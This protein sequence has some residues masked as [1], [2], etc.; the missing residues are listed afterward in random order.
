MSVKDLI[1]VA[2]TKIL[3]LANEDGAGLSVTFAWFDL[4]GLPGVSEP[5]RTAAATR[6]IRRSM[7]SRQRRRRGR[8]VV[9]MQR[10]LHSLG[11]K[12]CATGATAARCAVY[13]Q[14]HG[15]S[16]TIVGVVI[17]SSHALGIPWSRLGWCVGRR[18]GSH[19]SQSGSPPESATR[20]RSSS[21]HRASTA[22]T[23]GAPFANVVRQS[24]FLR[25]CKWPTRTIGARSTSAAA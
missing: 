20:P 3:D 21:H 13:W 23:F 12:S 8:P 2:S 16:G 10:R 1:A 25:C 9:E 24:N 5:P 6:G 11:A 22:S 17:C 15:A 7:K 18:R 4:E 19:R 14:R